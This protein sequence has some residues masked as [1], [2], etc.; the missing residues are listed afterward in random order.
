MLDSVAYRYYNEYNTPEGREC[1]VKKQRAN[2]IRK[3]KAL[4]T[5]D[6]LFDAAFDLL[7]EHDI[8]DISIKMI[9]TK[10]A[11]SIGTFYT[12]FDSKFDVFYQTYSLADR[13]F[14]SKVRLQ[15]TQETCLQRIL[16]F[17]D[18]YAN[19]SANISGLKIVRILFN[20]SNK[21][22]NRKH[23]FGM[24]PLLQEIIKTGQQRGEFTCEHNAEYIADFLMIS[25]RGLVYHW[26]TMDGAY[27]LQQRMHAY[28]ML[29]IRSFLPVLT[30]AHNSSTPPPGL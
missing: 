13:Y 28:C 24:L 15:L 11:V 5:K 3:L 1:V 7:M 4:E 6:R 29:W 30:D 18:Q 21:Y 17:F 16:Y 2:T 22:F 14:D 10:A 26:A 27:D 20:A 25:A 8:N 19:Y 23:D 9:T 12:Y